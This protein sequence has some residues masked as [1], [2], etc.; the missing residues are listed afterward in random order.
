MRAIWWRGTERIV[1]IIRRGMTKFHSLWLSGACPFY[2]VGRKLSVHASCDIRNPAL[3][4]LGSDVIIHKDVWL[5]AWPS[6]GGAAPAVSIGDRCLIGR[7]AHISGR[8]RI[9]IE[10]DA[11]VSAGVLIQ[12]HGHAYADVSVPINRQG[13]IRGGTIRIGA[14]AWLGQGAAIVSTEGDLVLGRNCVVAANAV[15]TRSTPDYSVVAGNPARVVKH[16]DERKAAWML[17]GSQ[18]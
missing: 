18:S 15:V 5:H 1:D 11:I 16:F 13:I 8:N 6:E 4:S 9:V 3:I 17:G 2:R 10:D 7:R 14:G 12:D